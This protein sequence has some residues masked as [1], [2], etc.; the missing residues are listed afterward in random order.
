VVVDEKEMAGW[1]QFL[2]GMDVNRMN[3]LKA[4]ELIGS[5]YNNNRNNA[6]NRPGA[7]VGQPW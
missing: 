1:Y 3:T 5:I 6:S 2:M 4:G 7:L